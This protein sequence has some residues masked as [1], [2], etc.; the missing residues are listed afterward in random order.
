MA[1]SGDE[2]YADLSGESDEDEKTVATPRNAIRGGPGS[3][4]AATRVRGAR[5]V[6]RDVGRGGQGQIR[7]GAGKGVNSTLDYFFFG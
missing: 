7:P 4:N 5:G 6:G 1:Y 3:R 2:H